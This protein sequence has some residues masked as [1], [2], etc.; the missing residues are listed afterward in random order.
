M[1][2]PR[3]HF[4]QLAGTAAAAAFLKPSVS[5]AKPPRISASAWKNLAD[6]VSG[7][8]LRP[9]D[10]GFAALTRPQNLRYDGI[11]PLGVARPR[12]AAETVAAIAW[13]RASR[14]PMVLRSGGHSYAGCS[15]VDGLIVHTGLMRG[16][17]ISAM[18]LWRSPVAP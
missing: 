8:V 16:Y 14:I 13:A 1:N 12:D 17:A 3:R 4:M 10:R 6:K 9:G 15:V 5:D 7:G 2:F 18:V 11:T